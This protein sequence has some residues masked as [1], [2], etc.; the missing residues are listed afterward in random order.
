M[1]D[2]LK[3]LAANPLAYVIGFGLFGAMSIVAGV[4]VLAGAGWALVASGAFLL[5]AASY[6]T[7]GLRPNG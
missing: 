6:I 7:K 3:A 2:K 1:K 4:A 5:A